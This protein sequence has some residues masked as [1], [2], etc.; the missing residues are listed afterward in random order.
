M[1]F[2][3][4]KHPRGTGLESVQHR[5]YTSEVAT[6][7]KPWREAGPSFRML[8]ADITQLVKVAPMEDGKWECG[9]KS[10]LSVMGLRLN[11]RSDEPTVVPTTLRIL[12]TKHDKSK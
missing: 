8:R 2:T 5:Y 12:H 6:V 11:V 3:P 4:D 1:F 7:K 9:G 10:A